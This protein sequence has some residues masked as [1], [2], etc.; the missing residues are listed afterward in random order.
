[1]GNQDHLGSQGGGVS[2][3][4]LLPAAI[5]PGACDTLL[6]S[7]GNAER[8]IMPHRT[9]LAFTIGMRMCADFVRPILGEQISGLGSDYFSVSAGFATHTDNDYVQALPGS[10]LSVWLPLADVTERNGPLVI[11]GKTILCRKGDVLLI[12]GDTPHRSCAG[13]GPR[14]VALFTYIKTGFPFR[15]G[16]QQKREEVPV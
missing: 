12:D 2:G 5:D 11:G 7:A 9:H 15:P 8:I 10:F 1:M 13:T 14:P 4:K 3:Y 16:N 6:E